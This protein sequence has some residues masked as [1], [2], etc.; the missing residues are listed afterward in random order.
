MLIGVKQ[1][2]VANGYGQTLWS[3]RST[4]LA[5]VV[6]PG[7][8][9]IC[10]IVD[11]P[12]H[13]CHDGTIAATICFLNKGHLLG[14]QYFTVCA[15]NDG[16]TRNQHDLAIFSPLEGRYVDDEQSGGSLDGRRG[17]HEHLG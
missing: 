12:R 10:Q 16:G 11:G 7:R 17:G 8:E 2:E 5:I 3:A 1:A 9:L 4:R 15:I 14:A 13:R 6:D